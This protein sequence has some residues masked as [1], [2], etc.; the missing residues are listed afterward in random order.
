MSP[1]AAYLVERSPPEPDAAFPE[2]EANV[3]QNMSVGTWVAYP[4][5]Y[6]VM[7]AR[8]LE[9]AAACPMSERDA[10]RVYLLEPGWRT[11]EI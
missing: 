3:K 10:Y 7:L 4:K 11:Q 9:P 1:V 2:N 8:S 6:N 5:R